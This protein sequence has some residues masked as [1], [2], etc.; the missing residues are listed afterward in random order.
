MSS[1]AEPAAVATLAAWVREAQR[2]VVFTGAGISTES[3]IPD[4]RSPGGLWEKYKPVMYQDF[5]ASAEWRREYWGRSKATYP[6]LAAAEPNLAHRA[7]V[8]LYEWGKLDICITQNIDRLHQR[9]GLPDEMVIELHGTAMYV[10]C[11]SCGAR[12]DRADVQVVLESGVDVPMCDSCDGILKSA[13]VSFGQPM[14]E[15]ETAEAMARS[16]AADLFLVVGSSLVVYPAA[17]CPV[18]AKQSGARV[19]IL[20]RDPTEHDTYADLTLPAT[21][22]PTMQAL[23]DALRP[24]M[25][26]TP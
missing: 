26:A 8:Q 9:A 10:D 25:P 22:G 18:L 13:T 24:D 16:R 1:A 15:R 23:I 19:V 2:L 7:L 11:Q 20:N 3:G 6:H 17:H 12:Y 4:F 21:A 5:M 14:P